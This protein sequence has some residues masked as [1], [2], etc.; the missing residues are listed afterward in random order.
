MGSCGGSRCAGDRPRRSSRSPSSPGPCRDHDERCWAAKK[1][2]RIV[3]HRGEWSRVETDQER[4]LAPASISSATRRRRSAVH[5]GAANRISARSASRAGPSG[6][7]AGTT[8]QSGTSERQIV[9]RRKLHRVGGDAR[10]RCRARPHAGRSRTSCVTDDGIELWSRISR[11]A[12]PL[13]SIAE[14]TRVER[15]TVAP[16]E[17]QP[18][19]DLLALDWWKPENQQ[20]P[21]NANTAR[22][23]DRHGAPRR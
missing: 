8:S 6:T 5:H 19:N 16:A 12:P 21:A 18:P 3:T 7:R 11:A 2:S 17:A 23:R 9:A 4:S 1:Q 10:P 14:A 15:R 20:R 22:F 13:I